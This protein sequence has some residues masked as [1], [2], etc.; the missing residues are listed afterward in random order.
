MANHFDNWSA[1]KAIAA[2]NAIKKNL[3]FDEVGSGRIREEALNGN[4]R[5]VFG[6]AIGPL[7]Y[8]LQRGVDA[9]ERLGSLAGQHLTIEDA[10]FFGRVGVRTRVVIEAANIMNRIFLV[11]GLLIPHQLGLL[12]EEH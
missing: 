10:N 9:C 11:D 2:K 1:A 12:A 8:A 6:V 3:L 7:L 5:A 4:G